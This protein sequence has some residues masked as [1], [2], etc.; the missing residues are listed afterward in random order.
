MITRRMAFTEVSIYAIRRWKD[1]NGKRRQKTR[2]FS[3][4]LNPF[5]KNQDG[6]LKTREDILD[7]LKGE[8]DSWLKGGEI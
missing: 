6:S 3:Q 2:K 7:E 5:N 8:R 1:E 4:T